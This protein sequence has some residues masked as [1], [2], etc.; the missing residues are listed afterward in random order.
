[1][2]LGV[3]FG[4]YSTIYVASPM[5]LVMQDVKPWLSKI[6][7]LPSSG[8]GATD[9]DEGY[10]QAGIALSQSEQRRRDRANAKKQNQP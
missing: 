10:A 3:I 4:T 2:L 6:V 1:M 8:S 7:V 9:A 5:I